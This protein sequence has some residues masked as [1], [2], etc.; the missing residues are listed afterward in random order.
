MLGGGEDGTQSFGGIMTEL[1]HAEVDVFKLD[2][3]WGEYK[4]LPAMLAGERLPNI[5]LVEVRLATGRGRVCVKGGAR[6][7]WGR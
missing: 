5:L 4:L 2:I 3:E 7:M 6:Q 1:R